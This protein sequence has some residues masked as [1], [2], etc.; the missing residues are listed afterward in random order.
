VKTLDCLDL[1]HEATDVLRADGRTAAILLFGSAAREK[2]SR[3]SDI[4]LLV[5][6]HG[7]VPEEVFDRINE[8][9]SITFYSQERLAALP[10][11]SPLFA[12]HLAREGR[13]IWDPDHRFKRALGGVRVLSQAD[14]QKLKTLTS[15]R[16]ASVQSD[17]FFDL[18]DDLTAGQLYALTKQ[19]AM[20]AS[21]LR[22][23][24]EFDRHSAL[25]DLGKVH[26]SF[27]QDA[28][29]VALLENAWLARRHPS[30]SEWQPAAALEARADDAAARVIARVVGDRD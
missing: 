7:S 29:T 10:S 25:T 19:A 21:A 18:S 24:F 14:A 13:A 9:V 5:L 16:L 6:H 20:L 22:G 12:I 3:T 28:Q 17:P 8:R 1:V 26:R 2:V 30:T 15:W 11:N 23:D 4:D 27:R